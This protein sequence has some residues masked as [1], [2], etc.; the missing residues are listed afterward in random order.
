MFR[1]R[2]VFL[3]LAALISC[4]Y[5]DSTK[6]RV[7]Q[8]FSKRE[9]SSHWTLQL[10]IGAE[11]GPMDNASTGTKKVTFPG[12]SLFI[13]YYYWLENFE[14]KSDC[15]FAARKKRFESEGCEGICQGDGSI[16][17]NYSPI[18]NRTTQITGCRGDW[19]DSQRRFVVYLVYDCDTGE[20]LTLNFEGVDPS[21]YE[22]IEEIITS[23][24]FRK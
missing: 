21:K 16:P 17:I 14:P 7:L 1:Y 2:L 4:T 6:D 5:T 18:V 23:L 13:R 9:I 8:G 3:S 19:E 10:P 11:I 15:S 24:E 22:L 20:F 12:D